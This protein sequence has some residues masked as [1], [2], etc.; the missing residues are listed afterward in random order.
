MR[1]AI[2]ILAA[3]VSLM[4]L[5]GCAQSESKKQ[6]ETKLETKPNISANKTALDSEDLQTLDEFIES[7]E[8]EMDELPLANSLFE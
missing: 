4:L 2:F 3:L 1:I 6:Q 7:N 5:L 8:S